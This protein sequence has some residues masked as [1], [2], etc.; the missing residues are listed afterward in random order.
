MAQQTGRWPPLTS[1]TLPHPV[2]DIV[3]L[4]QTLRPPLTMLQMQLPIH[5]PSM[6]Y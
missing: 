2:T 3:T 5:T 6:T 4:S 1:H